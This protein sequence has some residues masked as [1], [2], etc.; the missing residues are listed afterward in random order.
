MKLRESN[1]LL[2]VYLYKSFF[3]NL[4]FVCISLDSQTKTIKDKIGEIKQGGFTLRS[5]GGL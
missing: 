2:R 1:E 5:R 3:D 4:S